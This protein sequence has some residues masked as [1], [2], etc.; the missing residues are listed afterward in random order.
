MRVYL[1]MGEL[2]GSTWV[3]DAYADERRAQNAAD[4]RTSDS[5]L[6]AIFYVEPVVVKSGEGV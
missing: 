5:V 3:E 4:Y 2:W 1:V 6:G